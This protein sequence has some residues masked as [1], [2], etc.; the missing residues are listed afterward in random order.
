MKIMEY[1]L[2]VLNNKFYKLPTNTKVD[3]KNILKLK[4]PKLKIEILQSQ[5]L[6]TFLKK[7]SI[8]K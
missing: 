2:S 5:E 6:E 3:I 4:I 1:H 7:C 8:R